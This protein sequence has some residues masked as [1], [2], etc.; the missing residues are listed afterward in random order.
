MENSTWF[1]DK[2]PARSLCRNCF[3]RTATGLWSAMTRRGTSRYPARATSAP[4]ESDAEG[5]REAKTPAVPSNSR[6]K[7]HDKIFTTRPRSGFPP[8]SRPS[9]RPRAHRTGVAK[10]GQSRGRNVDLVDL[11]PSLADLCELKP[12]AGLDGEILAPHGRTRHSHSSGAVESSERPS[13][14]SVFGTPCGTM[15]TR[16]CT[17]TLP[18]RARIEPR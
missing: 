18:I 15:P 5:S 12:P 7:K 6:G 1:R 9:P 16:N 4:K 14:R 13:R 2:T 10:A 3:A 17:I 8:A 11:Y